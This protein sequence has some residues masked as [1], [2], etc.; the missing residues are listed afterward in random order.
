[1]LR[2]PSTVRRITNSQWKN[3]AHYRKVAGKTVDGINSPDFKRNVTSIAKELITMERKALE[4]EVL[5][6][7]TPVIYREKSRLPARAQ[8]PENVE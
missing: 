5:F 2:K 4:D 8:A 6:G 1:M 7:T 3:Y